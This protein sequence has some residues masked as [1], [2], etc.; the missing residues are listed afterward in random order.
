ML[1]GKVARIVHNTAI[2][3][4]NKGGDFFMRPFDVVVL[5]SQFRRSSQLAKAVQ[6]MTQ[7][8]PENLPITLLRDWAFFF[9]EGHCQRGRTCMNLTY[10]EKMGDCSGSR[11]F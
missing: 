10:M 5:L 8:D 3:R 9:L 1:A 11:I 2:V 7:Q 4:A 6:N